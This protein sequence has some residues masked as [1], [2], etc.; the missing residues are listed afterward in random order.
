M[1]VQLV[2]GTRIHSFRLEQGHGHSNLYR[3]MYAVKPLYLFPTGSIPLTSANVVKLL[4]Q[5]PDVEALYGVPLALKLLAETP[6]GLQV[7]KGLKLVMFGGSACP[8]ELGD[9]LV[10]EGVRLVGHY[11]LS[12]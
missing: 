8:D 3:A 7:L 10:N 6:E 5:A 12:K 4:Q 11:G 1:Y 2:I 9:L